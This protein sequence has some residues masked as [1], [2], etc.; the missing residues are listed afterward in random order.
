[1]FGFIA[2]GILIG[3]QIQNFAEQWLWKHNG[4][5]VPYNLPNNLMRILQNYAYLISFTLTTTAL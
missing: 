4:Y 1:M 5:F 3:Y 2:I